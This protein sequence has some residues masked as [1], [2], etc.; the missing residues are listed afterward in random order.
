[1][2]RVGF[3]CY[4]CLACMFKCVLLRQLAW[5]RGDGALTVAN[6]TQPIV[7]H[8]AACVDLSFD[9]RNGAGAWRELAMCPFRKAQFQKVALGSMSWPYSV[10]NVSAWIAHSASI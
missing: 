5:V 9:I 7:V 3:S 6:P 8:D 4:V 10:K 1:M 2:F